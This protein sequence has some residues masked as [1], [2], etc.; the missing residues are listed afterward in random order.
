MSERNPQRP[1][2]KGTLWLPAFS[3]LTRKQAAEI[4]ARITT[5]HPSYP[6]TRIYRPTVSAFDPEVQAMGTAKVDAPGLLLARFTVEVAREFGKL[7]A[8]R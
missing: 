4:L 8:P 5:E 3:D 1:T 7:I 6:Q 2:K